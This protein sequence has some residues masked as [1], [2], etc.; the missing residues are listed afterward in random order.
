MNMAREESKKKKELVRTPV[1][2]VYIAVT[3]SRRSGE[4]AVV[5]EAIEYPREASLALRM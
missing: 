3:V 5:D 2:C 4:T 1:L